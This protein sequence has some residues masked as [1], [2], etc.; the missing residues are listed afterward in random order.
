MKALKL[1]FVSAIILLGEALG[2]QAVVSINMTAPPK[3]GP[4]EFTIGRFYYLPAVQAYYDLDYS[5]FIYA[6]HG[7]W[8]TKKRLPSRYKSFDLYKG[9][10]IVLNDYLGDAPYIHFNEHKRLYNKNYYGSPQQTNGVRPS[11]R[12][13]KGKTGDS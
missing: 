9:Y 5:Q 12:S 2:A 4:A 8:V 10:K 11:K 3:W 1:L 13:S 6:S 7:V